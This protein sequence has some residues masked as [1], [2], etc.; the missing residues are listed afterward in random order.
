V[1]SRRFADLAAAA[2]VLA[3]TF[4]VTGSAHAAA[5][6]TLYV[7]NRPAANCSDAGTGTQAQP[8]CTI[9]AAVGAVTPGE[10]VSVLAANYPEHV[11]IAKSGTPS[12]PITLD[13]PSLVFLTGANGGLTIEGQHDIVVRRFSVMPD[14]PSANTFAVDLANSSRISLIGITTSCPTTSAIL[15]IRLRGVTDS[16][17]SDTSACAYTLDA[18]SSGVVLTRAHAG[19]NRNGP[20]IDVAGSNNT[21]VDSTIPARPGLTSIAIEPGAT[22]EIVA[23]NT[24]SESAGVGI[25]N[26]D[27]TGTAITNN[28]VTV[29]CGTGIRVAGASA[30]VSVQ[31]TWVQENTQADCAA[32]APSVN[33]GVYDTAVDDTVVD[34][35]SFATPQASRQP[36]AWQSPTNAMTLAQFQAASGQAAHDLGG[37]QGHEDSA[38]SDAPGF[39]PVDLAGRTPEDDP[40]VLNTG[41]G[42]TTYAD[43]GATEVVR[44][45][46]ASMT[47][48][49]DPHSTSAILDASASTPGWLPIVRYHFDFGDGSPTVDQTTPV[50]THAYGPGP[51]N[52][53][54][55]V[56][57]GNGLS[58]TWV[59]YVSFWPAAGTLALMSAANDR[60]V[61]GG[62]NGSAPLVANH[63]ATGPTGTFDILQWTGN[64]V[65]LRSQTSLKYVRVAPDAT[66]S[67]QADA[68]ADAA[69]FTV[70]PNADGTV[71]LSHNGLYVSAESAGAKPLVAN[72]VAIGPWE[73]FYQSILTRLTSVSFTARA[74]NRVVTA[75]S[76]GAKPL[77]ANRTAVGSWETFDLVEAPNGYVALFSHADGK[78]VTAESAGTKPLIANR[79]V[80]GAWEWFEVLD[81]P[82]GTISLRAVVNRRYVTAEDGGKQPLI[83]NRTAIG[84]WEGFVLTHH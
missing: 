19:G 61:D 50:A 51:V 15:G 6:T 23:N 83:A 25:D 10:T 68:P 66:L 76:A 71:S 82:D 81:N 32:S 12:Q 41:A 40:A 67:A 80:V 56:F 35:N 62:A 70:V 36:Y 58:A 65:V 11:T 84:L 44:G 64:L 72:R 1:R 53:S 8:Y 37:G 24:I 4:V 78:F 45:P 5:P 63:L 16:T 18:A 60:W 74:N 52:P 49:M 3:A 69:L 57:D 55:Q 43:R 79:S 30:H 7:D 75:E 21:V 29:S 2:L 59:G 48:T 27:A 33:I 22:G 14:A 9:S 20:G 73:K 13:A 46:S 28:T 54:V 77:I 47:V 38:N 26:N 42:P 34:Y 39:Q 31:N 17:L